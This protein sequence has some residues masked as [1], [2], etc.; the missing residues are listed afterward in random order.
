MKG[1]YATGFLYIS[2]IC[3]AKLSLLVLFYN[4]VVS[5]R[6]HRRT[7]VCFGVFILIWT[8]GSL[9]ALAF[10]CKLPRPWMTP[11]PQCFNQVSCYSRTA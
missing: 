4:I 1:Y 10:Q 7:V 11:G 5:H 9:L 2:A 6:L 8:L 3:L